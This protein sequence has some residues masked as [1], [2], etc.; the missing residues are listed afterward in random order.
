MTVEK[1]E[2]N[3]EVGTSLQTSNVE[4]YAVIVTYRSWFTTK[5]KEFYPTSVG[6]TY[7]S[8][9]IHFFQYV[10]ELGNTAPDKIS[11]AINKWC[12]IQEMKKKS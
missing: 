10:D 4:L 7:G 12:R 6:P 3:T 9:F 8:N 5:K 2:F 11:N 1:I